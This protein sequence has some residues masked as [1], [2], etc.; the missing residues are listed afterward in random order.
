MINIKKFESFLCDLNDL[1]DYLQE[2]FD[3]YR[4][5]KYTHGVEF[6]TYSTPIYHIDETKRSIE[7]LPGSSNRLV[8]NYELFN[9]I[10]A[11]LKSIKPQIEK[12]LG[13]KMYL[14]YEGNS[15]P[16]IIINL[17]TQF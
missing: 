3:K 15:W 12:R 7:I 1:E 16:S 17:S 9:K 11:E 6:E 8:D 10:F 5:V 4:I 13:Q 14:R 2:V